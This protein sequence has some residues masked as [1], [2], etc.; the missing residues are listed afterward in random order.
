MDTP[1]CDF[2]RGYADSKKLRLHM[3]G[4]KGHSVLGVEHLDI[5]E[6][7]GADVLYSAKGII[8]QSQE[9]A[10][11]LFGTAKTLFSTEGSSLAIRA[12]LYL[13]VLYGKA[14]GKR[15][16]IAAGRNA[17]KAFL[18]A[19]AL[20]DL[21]VVWLFPEQ[22][23]TILSCEITEEDLDKTLSDMEEKPLA[24]YITSPDYLGNR[25]DVNALSQVCH[26]HDV[27]LLVDNAHGA[28]LNFLPESQHPMALGAD[29]CCD[30]AHKTL[31]VLTGGAYLHVS[32]SAPKLFCEQAEQAMA[33]FASTS[34]SYLILQSLDAANRYMAEGYRERLAAFASELSKLKA[35]LAEAGYAMMGNE[36]MKLTIAAKSYGYTGDQLAELLWQQG[37]SC[38]FSDP[39]HLVLMFTPEIGLEGLTLLERALRGVKPK[40]PIRER[41]PVIST[42]ERVL[43]VREALFAAS[44]A[45]PVSECCGKVLASASVSC[46]P[47]IPI[48]VCG[49]RIGEAA[50]RC[51]EYYG[52]KECRVI[53]E[54]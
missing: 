44:R 34:P 31:P 43:S 25:A 29:L 50:I 33:L 8:K 52:I 35:R 51:F 47:A 11:A 7:S 39:D 28:Y 17:H 3:P 12:M 15:P 26:R 22:R 2:V 37:I 38:E 21:D 13:A 48:V 54:L 23:D 20:L 32:K 53:E 49:E 10:A 30:S 45:V 16:L 1:I 18:S 14:K 27:L 6:V 42:P 41:P 46:P 9:N 36:P 5:T 4:H 40:S 19:A 24:V